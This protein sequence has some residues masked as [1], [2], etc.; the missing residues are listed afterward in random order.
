MHIISS[1]RK[2]L[3]CGL[4]EDVKTYREETWHMFEFDR[5]NGFQS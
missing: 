1:M 3:N 4:Q 2:Q 5:E